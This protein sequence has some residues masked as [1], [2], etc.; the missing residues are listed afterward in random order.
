MPIARLSSR[1]E[2]NA[3]PRG[4]RHR[5]CRPGTRHRC[6][7]RRLVAVTGVTVVAMGLAAVACK[8]AA[9]DTVREAEW[10]VAARVK[11]VAAV[12]VVVVVV[13]VAVD[14]AVAV[15]VASVMALEPPS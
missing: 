7:C 4:R 15:A 2:R 5:R 14:W 10:A 13:A 3:P 12:V 8:A 6:W 11:V 1:G 9:R